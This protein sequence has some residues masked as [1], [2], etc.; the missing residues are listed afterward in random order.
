MANKMAKKSRRAATPAPS[1]APKTSPQKPSRMEPK[2]TSELDAATVVAPVP[3]GI[4]LRLF[5]MLYDSLL[6]IAIW[7]IV[8]AIL[9]PFGVSTSASSAHELTVISPVYQQFVLVPTLVLVTWLFYGYFW[10]RIGHTLGM[11][12]W[13]LT[14][15]RHSGERLRWSD[16]FARCA[17]ACLLPL[18]CGV[19]AQFAWHDYRALLCV[20]AGFLGNYLWILWSSNKM[21]WHDQLSNTMVWKLPPEPKANKRKFLGWFEEKND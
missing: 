9:V 5:A 7:M 14:V 19:I 10:R 12:T 13:R 16:A 8:S 15:L 11:Q 4:M 1:T 3:A 20:V 17:A 21:A 18:G 2:N 6:L